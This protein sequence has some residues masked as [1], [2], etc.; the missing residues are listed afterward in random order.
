MSRD[1]GTEEGLSKNQLLSEGPSALS[2]G[3]MVVNPISPKTWSAIYPGRHI[4]VDIGTGRYKSGSIPW[5]T[6]IYEEK[7]ATF[8]DI[9]GAHSSIIKR[10][11]IPAM[12]YHTT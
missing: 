12:L 10:P 7:G 6:E 8:D 1:L 9:F 11:R 2:A 3:Y 4:L 5:F